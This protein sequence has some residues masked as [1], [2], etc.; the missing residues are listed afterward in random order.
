MGGV[1]PAGPSLLGFVAGAAGS[2]PGWQVAGFAAAGQLLLA[3]PFL[4]YA[5]P[6]LGGWAPLAPAVYLVDQ[7]ACFLGL[8]TETL[9]ISG[10]RLL[11]RAWRTAPSPRF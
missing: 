7:A 10:R 8:T 9:A 5:M 1:V 4:L 11:S 2:E 6:R 3:L